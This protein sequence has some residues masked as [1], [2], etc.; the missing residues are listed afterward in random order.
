MYM[1][2]LEELKYLFCVTLL[3]FTLFFI[4][5]DISRFFRVSLSAVMNGTDS[6]DSYDDDCEEYE[7]PDNKYKFNRRKRYDAKDERDSEIMD[8]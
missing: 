1:S 7:E 6:D 2:L 3:L 8:L 4:I 5:K